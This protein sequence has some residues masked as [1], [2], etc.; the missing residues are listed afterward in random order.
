MLAIGLDGYGYGG[1]PIDA[2]GQLLHD[3]LAYTRALIPPEFPMHAL[4]VGQPA[5]VAACAALGYTIFDSAMPTRDARNG[6]LYTFTSD[7]RSPGFRRRTGPR[8]C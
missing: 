7:P 3:T 1:W 5:N 2:K 4:G 6:R 8:C